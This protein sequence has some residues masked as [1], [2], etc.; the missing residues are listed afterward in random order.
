[1]SPGSVASAKNMSE[2]TEEQNKVKDNLVFN[3]KINTFSE[4]REIKS[5]ENKD[6]DTVIK[7]K[8]AIPR[9]RWVSYKI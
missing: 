9:R 3:D 8:S 1:M 5:V 6:I 4:Q 7:V 2:N